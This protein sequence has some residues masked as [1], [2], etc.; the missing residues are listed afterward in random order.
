MARRAVL[1]AAHCVPGGGDLRVH[2]KDEGGAPVL[3][4]V[5]DVIR[6][7]GYR[8]DAVKSR[9]RSIDLALIRLPDD[10]PARFRPAALG[11]IDSA[12]VGTPFRVAGFGV[13]QE[14]EGASSGLLR[15]G[16]IEARAPLSSLLL[17]ARDPAGRGTGACTG[18]SGG[19]VLDAN[20]DTVDA[21][22]LWSAGD[23]AHR[24]G[25]LTQALWLGPQRGW[26]DAILHGWG[27]DR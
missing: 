12:A 7:P 15:Q 8:A 10:L 19:P 26:I 17:W 16:T 4:N 18:D 2:F 9:Q 13:G 5:A 27:L 1:T 21:L 14:G 23:G 6:H 22:T 25:A 11:S 3:L 24:C 20:S